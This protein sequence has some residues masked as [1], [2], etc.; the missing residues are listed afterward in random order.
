MFVTT[1]KLAF[2]TTICALTVGFGAVIVFG[3]ERTEWALIVAAPLITITDLV[4]RWFIGKRDLLDPDKGGHVA[5]IPH[6][7]IGIIL[8]GIAALML[9]G[10]PPPRR[11]G[12]VRPAASTRAL[13]VS[14]TE[15]GS[16]LV[17]P[18]RE[19]EYDSECSQGLS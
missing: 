13:V 8:G 11:R 9:Q 15:V 17:E 14:V 19:E 2:G 5:F 7:L 12:S 16:H 10:D 3:L 18:N 4:Y 6:W 1:N